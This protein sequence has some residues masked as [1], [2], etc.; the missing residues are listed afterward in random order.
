MITVLTIGT[1]R[2]RGC[3][4]LAARGRIELTQPFGDGGC[5]LEFFSQLPQLRDNCTSDNHFRLAA[6]NLGDL[7]SQIDV[8]GRG[9][10]SDASAGERR[11][12][13]RRVLGA[14]RLSQPQPCAQ[15]VGARL[16]LP[17]MPAAASSQIANRNRPCH[18]YSYHYQASIVHRA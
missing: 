3:P 4:G 10:I 14:A 6:Q 15:A 5:C 7:L 18:S 8:E 12:A 11:A 17:P 13:N 16:L 1:Y 2:L 9:P